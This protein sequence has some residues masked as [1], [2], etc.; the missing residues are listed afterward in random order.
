[1]PLI[2]LLLPYGFEV[3]SL[4]PVAVFE[5]AN[6]ELGEPFYDVRVLSDRG[7]RIAGSF[8]VAIAT[9]ALGGEAYDT[10]LVAGAPDVVSTTP[11]A[12]ARL[13]MVAA[14]SGRVASLRLG[15]FALAEAG[16]LDGRRATTHAT[17]AHALQ[18]RF[19]AIRVDA[20]CLF[21]QEDPVWTSAG[22]TAGVDLAL[23]L[24]ERDVGRDCVQRVAARLMIPMLRS[25]AH[26]QHSAAL[27]L[28]ATSDRVATALEFARNNLRR[29]LTVEDLA[30]V[31]R[32][33]PRQ[34]SRIFRNQTGCSP[35]RAIE[36]LRLEAACVLIRQGRL[37]FETIA[38]ETGFGDEE[39]MR[40]AFTR[41]V[42]QAPRAIRR[43]AQM[44]RAA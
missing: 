38:G 6:A 22:M 35:A 26:P 9:Q 25:G 4:T 16:L 30:E 39:R 18:Q 36:K 34:F 8:G 43:M 11:L 37:P 7:G 24:I 12:Q 1:M 23:H 27:D 15:A 21:T 17:H 10:L 31:A 20:D 13:R 2:G 5:A 41:D 14:R 33:S 44:A 3:C 42:G 32:L 29:K 40:R 19:P 28:Q